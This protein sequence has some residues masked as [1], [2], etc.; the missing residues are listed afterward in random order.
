MRGR[1]IAPPRFYDSKLPADVLLDLKV[2]RR[3]RVSTRGQDLTEERLRV[4]E[5]VATV[6]VSGLHRNI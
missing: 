5:I 2:K 6:Q 1:G 4:R 3:Q